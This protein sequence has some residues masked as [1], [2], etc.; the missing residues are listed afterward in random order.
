MKPCLV[1]EKVV[2]T[3]YKY[4]EFGIKSDYQRVVERKVCL[5]DGDSF[6]LQLSVVEEDSQVVDKLG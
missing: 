6:N 5:Q 3:G 2:L 1:L 4:D